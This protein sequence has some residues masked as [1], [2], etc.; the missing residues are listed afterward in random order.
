ML[1]I[2]PKT[3]DYIPFGGVIATLLGCTLSVT[4]MENVDAARSFESFQKKTWICS[5]I[6]VYSLTVP[7]FSSRRVSIDSR[8]WNRNA[9]DYFYRN[10]CWKIRC[11]PRQG[12][13]YTRSVDEVLHLKCYKNEYSFEIC[14]WAWSFKLSC[15]ISWRYDQP[16]SRKWRLKLLFLVIFR[17]F[18]N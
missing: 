2:S 18:P 17:I 11:V 16:F 13:F 4:V 10:V 14:H 3:A 8:V 15:K 1:P 12:A 7:Y 9:D 5:A 6:I